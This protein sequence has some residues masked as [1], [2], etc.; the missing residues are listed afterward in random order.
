[1][2]GGMGGNQRS[3]GGGQKKNRDPFAGMGMGGGFGNSM[4]DDDDDFFGGGFGGG[5]MSMMSQGGG[6]GGG[7]HFQSFQSSSFGGMG[8]GMG[9]GESISQQT[10][11]QNGQQKTI[12]K[13]TRRDHTGQQSTEIIEEYQDPRTGQMIRKKYTENGQIEGSGSSNMKQIG[14]GHKK[15]RR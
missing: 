12:T 2:H 1:M 6:F 9:M 13:K 14:D 8:G 4:F 3:K 7:G 5:G 10:V 15:K 11:I